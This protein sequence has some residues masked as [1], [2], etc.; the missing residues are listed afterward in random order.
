MKK[1]IIYFVMLICGIV[2]F[3]IGGFILKGDEVTAISSIFIGVGA[4]M[5]GLSI[6][7]IIT[8]YLVKKDPAYKKRIDREANDERNIYIAN[9]AK[10]KAYSYMIYAFGVLMLIY[11]LMN[12]DMKVILLLV[13]AYISVVG[14][15]IFYIN[16]Y[17]KEY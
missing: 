9:K 15:N 4:G 1:N 7:E 2:L 17:S 6:G 12:V 11:S 16:K 13:G 8:I 3:C 5:A 14:V 10:S